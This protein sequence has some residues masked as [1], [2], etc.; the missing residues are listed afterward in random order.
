MDAI[1]AGILRA[2]KD[3]TPILDIQDTFK[4]KKKH[5]LRLAKNNDIE[6][7]EPG[8]SWYLKRFMDEFNKKNGTDYVPLIKGL[9]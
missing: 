4:V 2:L 1:D 9:K 6:I 5:V 8:R 7:V 3:K